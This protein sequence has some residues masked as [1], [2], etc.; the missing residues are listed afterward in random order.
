MPPPLGGVGLLLLLMFGLLFVFGFASRLLAG[1]DAVVLFDTIRCNGVWSQSSGQAVGGVGR[2]VESRSASSSTFAGA[3][4]GA[5]VMVGPAQADLAQVPVKN[6]PFVNEVYGAASD[7]WLVFTR[8]STA[9]PRDYALYSQL[10]AGGPVVRVN[11][12]R[13][14]GWPG[15]IEGNTLIYQ[16]VTSGQSDIRMYDLVSKHAHFRRGGSTRRSGST[17]FR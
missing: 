3:L 6:S 13:T 10:L 1:G 16:Q 15:S 5:L 9:H 7:T 8:N 14:R 2:E 11:P 12:E 17:R 4:G